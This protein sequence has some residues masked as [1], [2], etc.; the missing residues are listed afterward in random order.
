MPTTVGLKNVSNIIFVQTNSND[1]HFFNVETPIKR[2]FVRS[3]RVSY[4]TQMIS[5]SLDLQLY[6]IKSLWNS[7]HSYVL[8]PVPSR[9]ICMD[10]KITNVDLKVYSR[11][12]SGNL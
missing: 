3:V 6:G 4:L 9:E 12:N 2:K 1:K 11:V 5:L 10:S 8:S 7:S